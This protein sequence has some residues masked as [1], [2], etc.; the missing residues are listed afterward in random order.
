MR[1]ERISTT[2]QARNL[3]DKSKLDQVVQQ[4]EKVI[5]GLE[6]RLTEQDANPFG[7]LAQEK[8][9]REVEQLRTENVKLAKQ[10][11]LSQTSSNELKAEKLKAETADWHKKKAKG[12]LLAFMLRQKKNLAQTQGFY[13]MRAA[14][15]SSK[16]PDHDNESRSESKAVLFE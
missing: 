8:L 11:I 13:Q 7:K 10:K 4:Y 12:L 1:T 3:I 9:Q 16:N 2:L 15:T 6:A 5:E 14:L